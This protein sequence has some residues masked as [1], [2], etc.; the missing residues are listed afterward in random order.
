MIDE[1]IRER[2]ANFIC[3]W[4]DSPGGR[5]DEAMRLANF[6]PSIS[7]RARSARWPTF[8]MRPAPTRRSWPWLATRWWFIR[9]PCSAD[10][11]RTSRRPAEI[12]DMRGR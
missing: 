5:I 10:R 4:I 12:D 6:W 2:D 9:G 3:L 8:P 11:G 7:T 1:Q